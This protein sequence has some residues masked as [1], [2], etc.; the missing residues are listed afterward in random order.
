MI[1]RTNAPRL[2][3]KVVLQGA[4]IPITPEGERILHDRGILSV[5]DFVANAGGVI[6]AAVE[7]EG[8]TQKRAFESIEE[9][10]REN[11][12]AVLEEAR[13]HRQMPVEAA[14]SLAKA[15]RRRSNVVPTPLVQRTVSGQT[16]QSSKVELTSAPTCVSRASQVCC[17]GPDTVRQS[18]AGCCRASS[19]GVRSTLRAHHAERRDEP[20]PREARL[21]DVVDIAHLGSLEGVGEL[22]TSYSSSV[23]LGVLLAS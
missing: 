22:R 23:P 4:N 9:K 20:G 13:K 3:C 2:N 11:T 8:G 7:Y 6:C 5:P 21:E 1:D 10:I 18:T 16:Q 14:M 17:G 19:A 12:T 15:T